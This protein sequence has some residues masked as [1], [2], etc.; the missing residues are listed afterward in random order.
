MSTATDTYAK[1]EE[2]VTDLVTSVQ[3]P[4]VANFRKV[5]DAAESRLNDLSL[6]SIDGLPKA[7]ELVGPYFEF[8]Q[9]VLD[10]QHELAKS[11]LDTLG[12][13]PAKAKATA[14]STVASAKPAA[15]P[16]AKKATKATKAA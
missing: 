16:A 3:E 4:V 13:P 9:T 10:K 7:D 11:F 2:K 1:V 6:P 15:K 12:A 14:K 5:A 8:A